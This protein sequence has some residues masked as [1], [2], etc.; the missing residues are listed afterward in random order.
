MTVAAPDP[1]AALRRAG[2]DELLFAVPG[3]A[4]ANR[5]NPAQDPR[6]SIRGFGARSAFGVRGVRVLQDGVPV[7]LPDGQTP[8]DVARP[9]GSRARRGGA[10]ECVVALRQRRRRRDRRP[11]RA[12]RRTASRH[13]RA[14]WAADRA[15]HHRDWRSGHVSA[16]SASPR[17]SRAWWAADIA[18]TPTSAPRR[19]R[20]ACSSRRGCTL[21]T[22]GAVRAH[23]RCLARR[24]S[25]RAHARAVRRGPAAGRCAIVRKGAGKIVRQ[26]DVS[27]VAARALGE[28]DGGCARVS[29]CAHAREPARLRDR[30]R[31]A[32][33]WWRVRAREWAS[34]SPAAR[35]ALVGGRRRAVAERRP[36]G[37]RELHQRRCARRRDRARRAAQGPAR[38]RVRRGPFVRGEIALCRAARVRGHPE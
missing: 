3:V 33:E 25:W 6:V 18:S 12:P 36:A 28:R 2:V 19:A 23:L 5:Q 32:L 35:R 34:R 16:P 24:E 37:I 17:P 31:E 7:T 20:C 1:L 29:E 21:V 26:G 9:R 27:L 10:R 11:L 22:A 14:S 13:L 38:A 4:L 15:H 30:G 8:V